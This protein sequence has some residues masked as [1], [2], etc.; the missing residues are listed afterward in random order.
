MLI[1]DAQVH[2]YERDRPERPWRNTSLAGPPEVTGDTMVAAMDDVGVDGAIL[3]SPFNTYGYDGSYALEVR[4]AHAGRFGLVVPMD[5]ND[6]AVAEHI[7]DWAAKDGTVGIRLLHYSMPEDAAHPG[8]GR[9]LTA[10]AQ[11]GMVVNIFGWQ[12]LEQIGAL[13]ARHPNTQIVIDHLG[14][15]PH[16]KPPLPAEPFSQ[17]SKVAKLAAHDN[18]AIKITGACALSREPFPYKDIWDPVRRL[19]DAFSFERCMWGTDWTR[20]TAFLTY[21]QGVDAFS[22]YKNLSDSERGL[23]MGETAARIYNWSPTKR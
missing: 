3:V 11:H 4:A 23:L 20:A 18:I 15:E 16:F 7:A 5:P 22:V 12:R 17:V 2:T 13:A 10:A 19:F 6:P 14:L 21:K 8:I 1:L 9:A